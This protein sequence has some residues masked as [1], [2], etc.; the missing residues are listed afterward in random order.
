MTWV[1]VRAARRLLITKLARR[2][3]HVAN[4]LQTV[5]KPEQR[6]RSSLN[7]PQTQPV[8]EIGSANTN[9]S[10]DHLVLFVWWSLLKLCRDSFQN[11]DVIILRGCGGTSI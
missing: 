4:I 9:E 1:K 6:L 5:R 2:N 10:R 8:D 3:F 7:L 11:L